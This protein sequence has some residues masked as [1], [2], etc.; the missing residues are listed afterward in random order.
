MQGAHM[1]S[2][3][4][5][6]QADEPFGVL[7]SNGLSTM[8]Y[9]LPAAIA[10]SLHEPERAVAAVTGDGGMAMCLSELATAGGAWLQIGGGRLQ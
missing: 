1:F 2:A 10:S 3:F 6:W 7:K 5:C 4:A 9:A 8:G